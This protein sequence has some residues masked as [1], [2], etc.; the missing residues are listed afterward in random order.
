MTGDIHPRATYTRAQSSIN[1]PK[2]KR[3]K[4]VI[5]AH[6]MA[7][8]RRLRLAVLDMNFFTSIIDL[9]KTLAHYSVLSILV[10]HI[11]ISFCSAKVRQKFRKSEFSV[12]AKG[13]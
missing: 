13:E 12:L 3:T 4:K 1:P 9:L 11:I 10:T 5:T 6:T 2:A 8:P 7:M